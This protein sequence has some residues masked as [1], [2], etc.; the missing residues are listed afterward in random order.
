[1]RKAECAAD[2]MIKNGWVS[3]VNI[4]VEELRMSPYFWDTLSLDAKQKAVEFW[5]LYF[6]AH[7]KPGGAVI[8]SDRNDDKLGEY[9]VWNGTKIYR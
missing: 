4:D 9:D 2:E 3:H 6:K 7:G 8:L 1:M 5:Y